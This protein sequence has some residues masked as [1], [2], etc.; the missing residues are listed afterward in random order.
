MDI[1]SLLSFLLIV[2]L[3]TKFMGS[4]KIKYATKIYFLIVINLLLIVS[5]LFR[6]Y[7]F[8]VLSALFDTLS[9]F[10]FI[11]V[12]VFLLIFAISSAIGIFIVYHK[13]F[14]LVN[15]IIPIISVFIFFSNIPEEIAVR[16]EF[17]K[18]KNRLENILRDD[19]Y[20]SKYDVFEVCS[21]IY[22]FMH[23]RRI[24][25]S[26]WT[27]IV[28]NNSG[29]LENIIENFRVNKWFDNFEK[30]HELV[31]F[32]HRLRSIERLEENWYLC[33]FNH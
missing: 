30:D 18:I 14:F 19:R 23:R 24:V 5:V 27:G 33:H 20:L 31:E 28:H 10:I 6:H 16:I 9:I 4:E 17:P 12:I 8:N 15:L 2:K 29:T 11:V 13:K 25:D 26:S 22:V 7:L 21:G 1:F 3:S 32:K